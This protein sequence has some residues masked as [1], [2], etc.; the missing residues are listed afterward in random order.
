MSSK[1]Q[2]EL[3]DAAVFLHIGAKRTGKTTATLNICR[4]MWQQQSKPVLIYNIGNQPQYNLF[5]EL[6][7]D[8]IPRFN[9]LASSAQYPFFQIKVADIDQLARFVITYV[10]NAVIVLEDAT[11]YAVG[12]ISKPFREMIL[13]NRNSGNDLIINLHSLADP[14]PFLFRTSEYI[15]LRQTSDDP[16]RLMNK[17]PAQNKV[18]AAMLEIREDNELANTLFASRTICLQGL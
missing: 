16:G 2:T 3:R 4:S 5:T 10:R 14:A 6:Q 12:N 18:R 1:P 13:A 15:I 8:D 7:I 11:S 17:V 9:K